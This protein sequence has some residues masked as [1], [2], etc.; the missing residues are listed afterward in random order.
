MSQLIPGFF[1]PC[2]FNDEEVTTRMCAFDVARK[3]SSLYEVVSLNGAFDVRNN[4]TRVAFS[5]SGRS[6]PRTVECISEEG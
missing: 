5:R 1:E 4:V 2:S 6:D 3:L